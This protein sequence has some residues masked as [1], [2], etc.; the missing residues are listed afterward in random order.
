MEILKFYVALKSQS[1]IV[2]NEL[3]FKPIVLLQFYE[4]PISWIT[5]V[6][7]KYIKKKCQG[8][9]II[10]FLWIKNIYFMKL[11][12]KNYSIKSKNWRK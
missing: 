7:L 10:H 4:C 12:I 5:K 11:T 2:V 1:R 6:S 8:K 3:K 9:E